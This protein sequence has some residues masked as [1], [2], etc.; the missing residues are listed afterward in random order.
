[1]TGRIDTSGEVYHAM[2]RFGNRVAADCR[3]YLG[4]QVHY[5][6]HKEVN[7]EKSIIRHHNGSSHF[8]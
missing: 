3:L 5:A 6:E 2:L 1:M 4:Q 7:V 8:L